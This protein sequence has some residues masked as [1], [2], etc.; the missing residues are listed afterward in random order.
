[1]GGTASVPAMVETGSAWKRYVD[2]GAAVMALTQE[3]AEAIV[4][5]LVKAGEV[6][7]ERA[8]KAID[9]LLAQSRRNTN[10]VVKL[11]RREV[12]GQLQ[13]QLRALGV[14]TKADIDRLEA[15]IASVARQPQGSAPT[16][17]AAKSSATRKAAAKKQPASK[18]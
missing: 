3:R 1:M 10:E 4:R 15:K 16:G 8:Q 7:Q 11:V 9:E 17:G 13:G 12:Q 14:A 5:D 2:T 18:A 6:R